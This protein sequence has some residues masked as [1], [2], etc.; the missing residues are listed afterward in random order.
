MTF[1]FRV[2]PESYRSTI[3]RQED[4][5]EVNCDLSRDPERSDRADWI[6]GRIHRG[7]GTAEE[8]NR[9]ICFL[10]NV[11]CVAQADLNVHLSRDRL[12][13]LDLDSRVSDGA[14]QLGVAEQELDRADVARAPVNASLRVDAGWEQ[15]PSL[16]TA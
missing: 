10:L 6:G 1:G 9:C 16:A 14:F 8:R 7:R 2:S 5:P 3:F 13:V 4:Y 11:R 12:C 15:R